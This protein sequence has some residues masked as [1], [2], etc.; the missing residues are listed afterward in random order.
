LWKY[1]KSQSLSWSRAQRKGSFQYRII[2]GEPA[3]LSPWGWGRPGWHIEDTAITEKYFG[4]QYDIHGGARDLIFPH[5]EA[6]I[7][8]MEA[9]SGKK[10]LVKYWLHTG[11][12]SVGGRKMAKSLGNFVTIRDF[13]KIKKQSARLLRFFVLKTHYR[14]PINYD[15]KFLLQAE[16][17]LAR[18]DEFIGKIKNQKSEIRNTNQKSERIIK[19]LIFKTQRDFQAAME[20]DFNTSKAIAVIFD[21]IHKGNALLDKEQLSKN[22]AKQ[23]LNFFKEIDKFFNFIFWQKKEERIPQKILKLVKEREKYRQEKNW[24]EAD[25]IREE[26][27]KEGFLIEDTK[28]GPKIK[29]IKV[30]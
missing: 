8:Q 4:P 23:I 27:K 9:I 13:L 3:W 14:S 19:S 6:E 30:K 18:L 12:L 26:I 11:F 7:C 20:D 21:L 17:E 24:Q 1:A 22:T 29:R 28:K 2:N 15:E 16:K 5:H 10:P 25:K